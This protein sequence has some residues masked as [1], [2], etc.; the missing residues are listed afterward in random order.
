[1]YHQELQEA[2]ETIRE[3]RFKLQAYGLLA[4]YALANLP[5][6]AKDEFGHGLFR[7]AVGHTR[8][9]HPLQFWFSE[10]KVI[11]P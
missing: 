4:E 6:P 8:G 10:R 9:E 11:M 5:K 2:N 7:L 3:L 1:M